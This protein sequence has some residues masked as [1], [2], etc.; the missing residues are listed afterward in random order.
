MP[1]GRWPF[2]VGQVPNLSA[3]AFCRVYPPA[4]RRACPPAL[5]RACP[6]AVRRACPPAVR[7]ARWS[8]PARR[9]PS[10]APHC[11]TRCCHSEGTEES[12][13]SFPFVGQ[14]LP[15]C[16]RTYTQGKTNPCPRT[17]ST[18]TSP[19]SPLANK[20]HAPP[21]YEEPPLA[22]WGPPHSRTTPNP[23]SARRTLRLLPLE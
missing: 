2:L 6:P 10:P 14:D 22:T 13:R 23:P 16:P 3:V 18:N 5:R 21:Q 17:Q 12:R 7:R 4:A 11:C 20:G 1:A 15:S 19:P 9:I 8:L